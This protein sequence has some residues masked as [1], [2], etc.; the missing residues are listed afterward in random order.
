MRKFLLAVLALMVCGM[1]WAQATKGATSGA[2][3]ETTAPGNRP[4]R[5]VIDSFL[6]H[7]FGYD[8]NIKWEIA[9]IKPADDPAIS[10]VTI[11]LRTPQGGQEMK[12]FVTPDQRYAIAGDMLPFGPNPYAKAANELKA[13]LSGPSRGPA[14][15][16]V[17][18]VEFGDLQ[19]PACK[20]AQPTID[21]LLGDV[22]QARLVFQQFP[23]VTLHKWAF[24]AAK[25]GECTRQQKPDAF[26]T[27]QSLVYDNQPSMESLDEDQAN[28]KLKEYAV[29]AGA[30]A[31]KLD[32]CV[33]DPGT[34]AKIYKSM[35]LGKSVE[36][37]STPTLFI[38]GR[39]VANVS[40][41]PYEVLKELTEFQ[42]QQ[43]P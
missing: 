24:S 39:K 42:G 12:L 5:E 9:D 2:K 25:Y 43:E 18:I 8:P 14:D 29:Q 35:E 15:A 10:V 21:K 6:R 3:T 7:T 23:L 26:W 28:P 13:K 27:F 34:A 11:V 20:A 4:S 1:M 33:A 40:G 22:P 31:A 19:C 41:M 16:K 38:N 37:T 32:A 30:D 36:V 17:T